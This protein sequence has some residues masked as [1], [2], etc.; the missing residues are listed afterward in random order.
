MMNGDFGPFHL[1]GGGGGSPP[2]GLGKTFSDEFGIELVEG[3]GLH[4]A[5]LQGAV[6]IDNG[7]SSASYDRVRKGQDVGWNAS[8]FL[9]EKKGFFCRPGR[10]A[11]KDL[12]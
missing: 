11:F 7:K 12:H 10:S 2:G 1:V 8:C 9:T 5:D 6:G 3:D 4:G